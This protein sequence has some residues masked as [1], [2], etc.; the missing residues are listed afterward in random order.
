MRWIH[1]HSMGMQCPHNWLSLEEYHGTV[2]LLWTYILSRD[3]HSYILNNN[4]ALL[5]TYQSTNKYKLEH[6]DTQV[7]YP[8]TILLLAIKIWKRIQQLN[9]IQKAVIFEWMSSTY[10]QLMLKYRWVVITN[11]KISYGKIMTV[12]WEN[13]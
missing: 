7:S 11:T 12:R 8:S 3:A 1:L 10:K 2:H 5:K 13:Q 6:C 4:K 9:N